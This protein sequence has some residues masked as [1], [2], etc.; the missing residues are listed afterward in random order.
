MG[1]WVSDPSSSWSTF[2]YE[3]EMHE[4]H[5]NHFIIINKNGQ[6]LNRLCPFFNYSNPP[7]SKA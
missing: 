1:Q 6:D 7:S 4:R 2:F 3:R 5:E